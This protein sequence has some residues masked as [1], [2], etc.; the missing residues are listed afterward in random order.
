MRT[1]IFAALLAS[2]AITPSIAAAQ[3][4]TQPT[5][6][7][8]P[9]NAPASDQQAEQKAEG[10]SEATTPGEQTGSASDVGQSDAAAEEVVVTGSRVVRA[11][12][13]A[14][15]PVTVLRTDDLNTKAPSN[16]PDALN[17]LPVFN[18][19]ISN[20][21]DRNSNAGRVR[22]GN[23][24][25]L[26]SLGP[27]RVL[28][29][30][31]GLRLPPTGNAGGTDA[32]MIPQL[33]I[34]RIDVVTGGASA[35][36]GSDAVSGVV[37]F[38][39]DKKFTGL[40]LLAQAGIS[41]R[42]D[43]GSNRI[44][45]AVGN[46]FLDG[47]L[48]VIASAE[49]YQTDGIA[50]RS[51]R[52]GVNENYAVIGSG[53]AA[54]PFRNVANVRISNAS[55][56]GL[57]TSGPLSS[58]QFLPNGTVGAFNP[59]TP[60]GR[61]GLSYGGDGV[62]YPAFRSTLSAAATTE[63]FLG[64]MSY[65]F[66]GDVTGYV[67]GTYNYASNSDRPLPITRSGTT[68]NTT[69]YADNAFLDPATRAALGTTQS[70]AVSRFLSDFPFYD[71]RQRTRAVVASA[72]LDGKIGGD[73]KWNLNYTFGWT[74]LNS[75][76]NDLDTARYYAAVDAVRNGAGQ[77]VC[78][79][80]ITNPGVQDGCVPLNIQGYG[81]A[82][83]AGVGYVMRD[84][85]WQA[86]NRMHDVQGSISGEP[87]STWAGPVSIVIGGEYRHQTL[88]QVS[89]SNPAT[90]PNFTGIRGV[91]NN[92]NTFSFTNVSVASGSYNIKEGFGEIVVPLAKDSA[93]GKSLE[94]NAA[95]RYT[96]YSTSGSVQTWKAGG[97]YEPVGGVKVRGTFSRDIRAPTLYEL[98]AGPTVRLQGYSD[99]LTNQNA[100][101][102]EVNQGNPN[103]R[104]EIGSTFT[105]GL[106]LQPSFLPGFALSG[107]YYR[108]RI[109]DAIASQYSSLQVLDL[110]ANSNYTSAVC[111]QVIRPLG[112]TNTTAAN[113]P[114]R[115]N[116]FQTNVASIRTEGLDLEA[117]Y[118]RPLLGGALST[119]VLATRL[120]TYS[121][122]GSAGA[123]NIEYAGNADFADVGNQP[124][125]MPKWRGTFDIS[126]SYGGL[127]I[128][129][130][131]RYI[132]SYRRSDLF[133]YAQ[134]K[135]GAVAYT[136]LSL[137]YDVKSAR[138]TFQFFTTVN[139][140]FDRGYPIVPIGSNPGLAVSTFRSVYDVTGTYITTGV[141]I[142]Y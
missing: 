90:P 110:C 54:D 117:S 103:L 120:F 1:H 83:A 3:S 100:Q 84:S 56:G 79:V 66:G 51:S 92:T 128:G 6:D 30:Q 55:D 39:L 121:L 73:F 93:L 22:T 2:T 115:V 80:T 10:A 124:F 65:D 37:N 109:R 25:N 34:E 20:S 14:P 131:E 135:V 64:R 123:A 105:G 96:D 118:R 69:I 49:R 142:K 108:I 71:A 76:S 38:V 43:N 139:N 82:S 63:Q 23:Y 102:T 58:R 77:V 101:Y 134:N 31:D 44:G 15:T 111:S 60:T 45:A 107:D 112:P 75:D 74:K 13:S 32:N 141:R 48:H 95:F 59:G 119:R 67:Q 42:A 127:T 72:G 7:S 136:D 40:K 9:V 106:V 114:S 21:Q 87:F 116:I 52:A 138:N 89:N 57:I 86:V 98:F 140:L 50:N 16:L 97:T 78:R 132:G 99:R 36:Y 17:Q 24:L 29:L 70:F 35:A 5:G 12:Y 133:V 26:R 113:F 41:S 27:Q 61:A 81:N 4:A 28:V 11:G 94:L 130:Q 104:P 62:V 129:A 33:L 18:G 8:A 68:G 91:P 122:Q 19:S 137:T 88:A 125:P 53:T 47:R 126:Y 46:S 85:S